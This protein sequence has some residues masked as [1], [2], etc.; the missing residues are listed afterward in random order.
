MGQFR[1]GTSPKFDELMRDAMVAIQAETDIRQPALVQ[2]M[3]YV[4]Y[5][6]IFDE[7]GFSHQDIQAN[8]RAV[9]EMMDAAKREAEE[10]DE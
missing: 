7:L 1:L 5:M 3:F 9:L 2:S 6:R 10:D 4:F 8:V